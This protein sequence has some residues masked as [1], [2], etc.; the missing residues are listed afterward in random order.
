MRTLPPDSEPA[1]RREDFAAEVLEL[2]AVLAL[3]A[4][5]AVSSLGRRM[6]Q[7]LQPRS[8]ESARDALGRIQEAV[9]LA[10]SNLEPP[11]AGFADMSPAFEKGQ[12]GFDEKTL[13]QLRNLIEA[14]G[15]L[16]SWLEERG[17]AESGLP[18]LQELIAN[19]PGLP[20]LL[21]HLHRIIDDRGH[22]RS[23]ASSLLAKLR[24]EGARQEKLIQQRLREVM[25]RTAVRAVLSDNSVHRRGGRPVLAVR[26]KSAGRVRGILH[27]R[28]SSGESV[29]IE[30]R[31]VIEAGNHLAEVRVDARREEERILLEVA[32]VVFDQ[33]VRIAALSQG[34]GELELAVI[35]ARF[36]AR[37]DAHVPLL[38]GDPRASTG[39]SLRQAR[40][41]LLIE[42][43]ARGDLTEVV[44]IDLR[45]GV[46]FT[47]LI[48]TG[49]KIGRAHV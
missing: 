16:E 24:K 35:G 7:D 29:F 2:D 44:G 43:Q 46:D 33:R 31:E 8:S 17:G 15:R 18:L 37:Y 26:A 48:I 42:Q 5:E 25:G 6:L 20:S 9:L 32:Q 1:F 41:P 10:R 19:T 3:Y 28:S 45:L 12:R 21:A 23:D 40:H 49:P 47:M 14:R 38:P 39:L 11:M 36:A 13:A 4:R 22:L 27:D 30:P 34:L